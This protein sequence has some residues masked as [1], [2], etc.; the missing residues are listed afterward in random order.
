MAYIKQE[1]APVRRRP[2][3]LGVT[4]LVS[5]RRDGSQ[6]PLKGSERSRIV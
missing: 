6:M 2:N 5:W 1:L 3:G 4:Y